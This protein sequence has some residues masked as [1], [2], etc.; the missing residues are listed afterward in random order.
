MAELMGSHGLQD[1]L[2]FYELQDMDRVNKIQ[3]L[4]LTA[5]MKQF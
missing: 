1:E 5:C 3:I 4:W 2:E